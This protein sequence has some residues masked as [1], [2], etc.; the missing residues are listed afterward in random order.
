[1][2]DCSGEAR[3]GQWGQAHHSHG[4]PPLQAVKVE[5]KKRKGQSRLPSAV[6]PLSSGDSK[7]E[8]EAFRVVA[9]SLISG[10]V[11]TFLP[12]LSHA[13]AALLAQPQVKEHCPQW[14]DSP[15]HLSGRQETNVYLSR[16]A[17]HL[18]PLHY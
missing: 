1:M 2:K 17:L 6:F 16:L 13:A 12:V 15:P 18:A 7:N 9:G 14:L 3:L 5:D 11:R 10:K 8:E 4:D